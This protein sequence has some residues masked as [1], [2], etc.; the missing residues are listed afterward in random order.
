MATAKIVAIGLQRLAML[1]VLVV[2]AL[3]TPF[4]FRGLQDL[5][6]CCGLGVVVRYPVVAELLRESLLDV[7]VASRDLAV[8]PE[9][10]TEQNPLMAATALRNDDVEMMALLTLWPK[11][12]DQAIG[13]LKL[14]GVSSISHRFQPIK[15]DID[16][17]GRVDGDVEVDDRLA[18]QPRHRSASHMLNSDFEVTEGCR[19]TV[20]EKLERTRPSRVVGDDDERLVHPSSLSHQAQG[21]SG[22]RHAHRTRGRIAS[23]PL[24]PQ[25]TVTGQRPACVDEPTL[26]DQVI[27]TPVFA[28]S[29]LA[30]ETVVS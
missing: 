28:P 4:P 30:C 29:P 3:R 15:C 19:S 5:R 12:G 13:N 23:L 24:L 21:E 1:R 9:V 16:L 17:V 6:H 22:K 25:S 26:H 11:R 18:S 8:C 27:L 7:S 20:T 2:L 14:A 10:V